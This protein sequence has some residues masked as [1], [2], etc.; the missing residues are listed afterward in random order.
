MLLGDGWVLFL[1]DPVLTSDQ[2]S[3]TEDKEGKERR[4]ELKGPRG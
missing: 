2:P 1:F 3:S 4:A